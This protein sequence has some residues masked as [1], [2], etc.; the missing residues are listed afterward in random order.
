MADNALSKIFVRSALKG[1]NSSVCE[2]VYFI[3]YYLYL[4]GSK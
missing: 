1:E 2:P 3:Q 4:F